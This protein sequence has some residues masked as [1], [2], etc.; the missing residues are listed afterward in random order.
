MPDLD[1]GINLRNNAY[2]IVQKTTDNIFYISYIFEL[3]GEIYT[4]A[5]AENGYSQ[6]VPPWYKNQI[7]L[8]DL[9]KYC[10]L[11][12]ADFKRVYRLVTDKLPP[13][14][15]NG[16]KNSKVI[17]DWVEKQ[18]KEGIELSLFTIRSWFFAYLGIIDG[19]YFRV[20]YEIQRL[21]SDNALVADAQICKEVY[22]RDKKSA[23][24]LAF[25]GINKANKTLLKKIEPH[26]LLVEGTWSSDET[27]DDKVVLSRIIS[28][29]EFK[30][31]VCQG[32][33]RE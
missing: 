22:A 26:R 23:L 18:E 14:L 29:E 32:Q 30:P 11:L 20:R 7:D 6:Y 19:K 1:L 4:T 21:S 8:N 31:L 28:C 17:Q 13:E 16:T 15:W 12:E 2:W 27:N 10:D 9:N 33:R 24:D 25:S 3:N 5:F